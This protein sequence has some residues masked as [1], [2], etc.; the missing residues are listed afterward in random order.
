MYWNLIVLAFT[1]VGGLVFATAYLARGFPWVWVLHAF[2]G[3]ALFTVGMGV[4]FY[5]GNAVR[6]F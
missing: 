6:P 5:S 4:F 3:N 2:A 1:F